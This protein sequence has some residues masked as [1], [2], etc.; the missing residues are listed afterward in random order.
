MTT[1]SNTGSAQRYDQLANAH[2]PQDEHLLACEVSRLIGTG[3]K[4]RDVATALRLDLGVVLEL[5]RATES[6]SPHAPP[7]IGSFR[8]GDPMRV[9]RAAK[10]D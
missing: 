10:L 7:G 6:H 8:E 3:L 1:S 5:L 4:T 9:I 2:R